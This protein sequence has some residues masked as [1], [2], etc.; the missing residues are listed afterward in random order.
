MENERYILS[1]S[2][3]HQRVRLHDQKTGE[4][5]IFTGS[6]ALYDALGQLAD[7]RERDLALSREDP[8]TVLIDGDGD[9]W[10]LRN[11]GRYSL[12][13][14]AHTREQ[15]EKTYGIKEVR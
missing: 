8:P 4:D 7:W 6:R 13:G 10:K 15:I 14:M 3:D 11:D 1:V 5:H 2:S 12:I 9:E